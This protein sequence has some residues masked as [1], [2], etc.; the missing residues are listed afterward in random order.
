MFAFFEIINARVVLAV[1]VVV[2]LLAI[3]IVRA[4]RAPSRDQAARAARAR[5]AR[6]PLSRPAVTVD[7]WSPVPYEPQAFNRMPAELVK[8][9]VRV[10]K[11]WK[12]HDEVSAEERARL[13]SSLLDQESL[14]HKSPV[15]REVSVSHTEF[16]QLF[17]TARA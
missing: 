10:M 15:A 3:L 2:L 7:P 9:P 8:P 12:P 6:R 4:L 13:E 17:P 5:A 11:P 16:S 1:L 14:F